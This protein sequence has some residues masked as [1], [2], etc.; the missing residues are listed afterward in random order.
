MCTSA[1][2]AVRLLLFNAAADCPGVGA[3]ALE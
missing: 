2:L 3:G 1:L